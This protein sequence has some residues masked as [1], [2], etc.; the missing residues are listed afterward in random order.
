MKYPLMI[1]CIAASLIM[2]GIAI[3]NTMQL[4]DHHIELQLQ[5]KSL[6]DSEL[7]LARSLLEHLKDRN[8][9]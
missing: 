4:Y 6:A 2:S 8:A 9:P 3:L 7:S 5:V 1:A